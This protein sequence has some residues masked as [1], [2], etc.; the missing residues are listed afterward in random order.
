MLWSL[1]PSCQADS[2]DLIGTMKRVACG[3]GLKNRRREYC[4]F[5]LQAGL[6]SRELGP[7]SHCQGPIIY[8][9]PLLIGHRERRK[10][11]LTA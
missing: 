4:V 9:G 2:K 1:L 6:A 11:P 3:C 10:K 8:L 7:T 5:H